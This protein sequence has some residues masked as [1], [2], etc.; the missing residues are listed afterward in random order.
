VGEKAT[1]VPVKS[2]NAEGQ[3]RLAMLEHL[4]GVERWRRHLSDAEIKR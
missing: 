2:L 3:R 1:P 4:W